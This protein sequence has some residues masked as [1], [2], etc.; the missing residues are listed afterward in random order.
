[1]KNKKGIT[2]VELIVVIILVAMVLAIAGTFMNFS[3]MTQKK[4]ANEYK[5]QADLRLASTIINN[6]I[7]NSTVTF[8]L[9]ITKFMPSSVRDQNWNYIGIED[10]KRVVQITPNG[11]STPAVEVLFTAGEGIS[12]SLKFAKQGIPDYNSKLIQY[13][14]E[15]T[16]DSNDSKK[17]SILSKV[18]AINSIAVDEGGSLNNPAVAIA[19]KKT[20]IPASQTKPLVAI[21][22]VLDNSGSMDWKM[23]GLGDDRDKI[24]KELVIKN[25]KDLVNKFDAPEMS[26]INI[27]V[28]PFSN[29]ANNKETKAGWKTPSNAAQKILIN[30][31][32]ES[33]IGDSGTNT[34]DAMRRAY[35]RLVEFKTANPGKTI[36]YYMILIT[37]GNPTYVSSTDEHNY[38]PQV[39]SADLI[40][41]LQKSGVYNDDPLNYEY[42][43]QYVYRIGT[44]MIKSGNPNIKS[45]VIGVSGVQN[46]LN[47][48]SSIAAIA[49]T[50]SPANPAIVGTYYYAG[51]DAQI[52]AAFDSIYTVIQTDIWHILGPY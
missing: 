52:S 28:I 30:D 42:C 49:C 35:A 27:A 41:Y 16:L 47:R 13:T 10:N 20:P 17:I 6:E 29:N 26:N 40:Y 5:I 32:I 15:A 9:P 43:M 21:A 4:S 7:R 44:D 37:D 22:L 48:A 50:A 19:Y 34:G 31:M 12:Y 38:I 8:T 36:N 25:A 45:F 11:T 3:F 23:G 18:E 14:I 2:L 24:R 51:S 46:D 1:M 39:G 33:I